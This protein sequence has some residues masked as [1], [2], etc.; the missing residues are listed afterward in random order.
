V[1][2]SS[3]WFAEQAGERGDYFEQQR[4]DPGL[5]VGGVAGAELGDGAAVL[6]L[7]GQLAQPCGDRRVD[8]VWLPGAGGFCPAGGRRPGLVSRG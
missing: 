2:A 5:L 3:A 8:G 6:G 7:G 4:V 1:V